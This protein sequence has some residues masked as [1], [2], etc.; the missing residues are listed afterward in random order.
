[1]DDFGLGYTADWL[2]DESLDDERQVIVRE[3]EFIPEGFHVEELEDED[4]G[5]YPQNA[6]DYF[7]DTEFDEDGPESTA[8]PEGV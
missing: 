8:E 4:E 5:W 7:W 1:M 6:D 3:E 2:D